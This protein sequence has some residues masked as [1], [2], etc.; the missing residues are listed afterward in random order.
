MVTF[1]L[2]FE[3]TQAKSTKYLKFAMSFQNFQRLRET[4]VSQE[5]FSPSFLMRDHSQKRCE[6]CATLFQLNRR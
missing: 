5:N 6:F 3:T 2:Q 4:R 1:F